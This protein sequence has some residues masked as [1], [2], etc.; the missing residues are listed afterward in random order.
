MIATIKNKWNHKNGK[1]T[2]IICKLIDTNEE[3]A[4][5]INEPNYQPLTRSLEIV[6]DGEYWA[7][8]TSFETL[9]E[10]RDAEYSFAKKHGVLFKR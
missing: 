10:E 3:V 1:G 9:E 8:D 5:Y 4:T 7:I 6:K 2:V